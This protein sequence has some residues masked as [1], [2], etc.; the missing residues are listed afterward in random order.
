MRLWVGGKEVATPVDLSNGN[1]SNVD[2]MVAKSQQAQVELMLDLN[3]TSTNATLRIELTSVNAYDAQGNTASVLVG[4]T[5]IGTSNSLTSSAYT[6]TTGGSFTLTGLSSVPAEDI[7]VGDG[8]T[9][10][11]P[12]AT[13]NLIAKDDDIKV[14]DLY[15]GNATS[16]ATVIAT[17]TFADARI[18]TLGIFDAAG[19]LKGAKTLSSGTVHF[20]L[21]KTVNASGLGAIL[22]PK[23]TTAKMTVKVKLNRIEGAD[24]TGGLL[25]LVLDSTAGTGSSGVTV[26]SASTGADLASSSIVAARNSDGGSGIGTLRATSTASDFFAIRRTKPALT[27]ISQVG[28]S[29]TELSD[30]TQKPVYRFS[31][32]ANS[33]EDVAW[34]GVKFAVTGSLGSVSL[35]T[36]TTVS[37]HAYGAGK[38]ASSTPTGTLGFTT[39]TSSAATKYVR[40][41]RLYDASSNQEIQNQ[42]YLVH[43][44]WNTTR[45]EGEVA[46]TLNNNVEEV[47]SAG[48]SKTY[49]LR[50]DVGG[51]AAGNNALNV[52]IR[53]EA[54]DRR[55][56]ADLVAGKDPD[57]VDGTAD[58]MIVM[59]ANSTGV[60]T[61]YSFLWSDNSGQPHSS[62]DNDAT[63]IERD[64]TNDRF[65]KIDSAG[66]NRSKSF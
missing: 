18:S 54:N 22:V 50:A 14:T 19:V 65:V 33:N 37:S 44:D 2:F 29:E 43:V 51:V 58:G 21:G 4:G 24:K 17:S 52:R 39:A 62:A 56:A 32:A 11:Y 34:K 61:P 31:I 3:T 60:T 49:E 13:Y 42:N 20:D 9:V 6:V 47:V 28:S 36:T 46:I 8:G 38:Y 5:A 59:T 1:F 41:F 7:L 16:T 53:Q 35:A 55:G 40:S 64:W 27:Q 57:E 48:T 63:A 66:W 30:F 23:N 26:Q 12:V 45:G 25:R 10:W 15:F